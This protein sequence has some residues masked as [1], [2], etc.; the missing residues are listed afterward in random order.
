MSPISPAR[1]REACVHDVD[2]PVTTTLAPGA[3]ALGSRTS[4]RAKTAPAVFLRG[5]IVAGRFEI[6]RPLGQ[7]GMGQVFAAADL[8]L[9]GTLALKVVRPDLAVRPEVVTQLRREVRLARMVTHPNVCRIYDVTHHDDPAAG[10][11]EM[12]SLLLLTMELLDGRT[13]QERL[14]EGGPLAVS[15]ALQL[16]R[17]MASALE[18]AHRVGVVHRDFKPGNVMLLD[19][20]DDV[21]AVV[22]D[23]GVAGL[24]STDGDDPSRHAETETRVAGTPAYM[25]PEERLGS[26]SPAGDLFSLGVVAFECLTGRRPSLKTP[27]ESIAVQGLDPEIETLLVRCLT[28][29]PAKRPTPAAI[30][31]CL[32]RLVDPM[33]HGVDVLVQ[34]SPVDSK[35]GAA[36]LA[37]LDAIVRERG[38]R[39]LSTRDQNLL[40]AVSGPSDALPLAL[41]L[42]ARLREELTAGPTED[43]PSPGVA[44]HLGSLHANSNEN[45]ARDTV[46]ALAALARPGQILLSR[47]ASDLIRESGRP[48]KSLLW[49]SHGLYALP[50]LERPVEVFEASS[51]GAAAPEAPNES[52]SVRKVLSP[53]T[54][55]GWRPAVG[56]ELPGRPH[57]RI[58]R[59]LGEGG[60]GDVWLIAHG[61]T[62]ER[63]VLKFCYDRERLAGLQR[64]VT[65][66]RFLLEELG[67]RDDI[68]RVIDWN[69]D[70]EPYFIEAE[71][72]AGGNLLDWAESAGGIETVDHAMRRE[73]VAQVAEAL[74]A[75]H[76]VGVLHRD[77]KP[78]NVLVQPDRDGRPQIRLTDFGI[79]HVTDHD[80]LGA[81]GITVLG[82]THLGE[83]R[84]SAGTRL[85]QAPELLEGRAPTIQADVYA[86]GVLLFQLEVGD[87]ARS[88]SAGWEREIEDPLVT[89]D[90]AE[91]VDG[92]PSR[93][94]NAQQL[95]DRLRSLEERRQTRDET[96]R[97][98]A[99][100]AASR[101]ALARG[102]RRRRIV[103]TVSVALLVVATAMGLLARSASEEARRARDTAR[104]AV[105]GEWL[106][107]DPTYA[108]LA[109]L[110]VEDP[111]R[112][113][114][115]IPRARELLGRRLAWR[116]FRGD[117]GL[118]SD[119]GFDPQ[120]DWLVTGEIGD[121]TA[122]I[123]PLRGSRGPTVLRG[124]SQWARI[125]VS[126]D[127][128][129]ILTAS[130]D[131]TARVWDVTGR[132]GP[133]VLRGHRDRLWGGGFSPDGQRVVTASADGTARIWNLN[134]VK[135]P[136]VLEGHEGWVIFAQFSPDGRRIVTASQDGTARIWSVDGLVDPVVLRGH[137]SW[138]FNSV[139]IDQ[140]RRILT[141]SRDGTVREWTSDGILLGA[142][143]QTEGPLYSTY[144]SDDEAW[145]I[146]H[147]AHGAAYV[148]NAD[149]G[150]QPRVIR[151]SEGRTVAAMSPNG[152]HFAV[153]F[154]DGSIHLSSTH[155]RGS[156]GPSSFAGHGGAIM[157]LRFSQDGRW[158]ASVSADSTTRLW[159]VEQPNAYRFADQTSLVRSL[160]FVPGGRG[161]VAGSADGTV[162][163]LSLEQ[164]TELRV[165]VQ[166]ESEIG[167]VAVSANGR[168]FAS[169]SNDDTIG[170]WST[171]GRFLTRLV[172]HGD[173]LMQLAFDP[174]GDSLITASWEGT[175]LR[176]PLHLADR[177]PDSLAQ[178]VPE[179]V[180]DELGYLRSVSIAFDP[181]TIVI[182]TETGE[183][184]AFLW[185]E[186]ARTDQV[187]DITL[188]G[189][190]H[191]MIAA[192][193]PISGTIYSGRV[194]GSLAAWSLD[195]TGTEA[196][197]LLHHEPAHAARVSA[198]AAGC[199]G[200]K[201]V[202]GSWDGTARAWDADLR[203]V[204][205]PLEL[206]NAKVTS[207]ACDSDSDLVVVGASSGSIQTWHLDEPDP[208]TV[209]TTRTQAC[210][211]PDFR[212]TVLGETEEVAH[213]TWR[214]CE[215]QPASLPASE[216]GGLP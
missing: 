109:L 32:D 196:P 84:S 98:R 67:S 88:L 3:Q 173:S 156:G 115:A 15:D 179:T 8:E 1:G 66:F 208:F 31:E 91:A 119:V 47:N 111:A 215:S 168:I 149:P 44:L 86:L 212:Q 170:L 132:R 10:R 155:P 191:N 151:G 102:R 54:I 42:M 122:R 61:K 69:L 103:L 2:A 174:Q 181:L 104:A 29:N 94:P 160:A 203:A 163:V 58:I 59:K 154:S 95:A 27:T 158:L 74:S 210:L 141:S 114:R 90:I 192:L 53:A 16:L 176:W 100:A 64:E 7:G 108:A 209:L 125:F 118:V 193:E 162:R 68:T 112:T 92:I 216:S 26:S 6:L 55:F 139:F 34:L 117:V 146:T 134:D 38:G 45:G 82:M 164:G 99:E 97:L 20:G 129:Q 72:T 49:T 12:A 4:V 105:A 195:R 145:R 190:S 78:A 96:R 211:A 83:A 25:A 121:S 33:V 147:S 157:A 213:Q 13:L 71:Y 189:E 81:A 85:Y 180:L 36:P 204:S 77:V 113:P 39:V 127:G 46:S 63:R 107:R 22:T 144:V 37:V 148:W 40:A 177:R 202:S 123:W 201:L 171:D 130:V 35:R 128:H 207:V 116:E 76:S 14:S 131:S 199:A 17:Q 165:P 50:G 200:G 43:A 198:L 80:R 73:L 214:R 140:G 11:S 143:L 106:D 93:R 166:H 5:E 18:S 24:W 167:T 138:I 19:E 126:P 9:G 186:T 79:G 161:V 51:R 28:I 120:G 136:V 21:R 70:D 23:F 30:L 52:E 60:F 135:S 178:V 187:L 48:S 205:T 172:G 184:R 124:H 152:A 57:W 56:G 194:D 183:I 87:L 206:S 41:Q 142:R 65:L 137:D 75:A 101:E 175:I 62:R 169:G 153:G 133:M 188:P 182:L 150:V 89:E 185:S 159:P 110:E 197:T